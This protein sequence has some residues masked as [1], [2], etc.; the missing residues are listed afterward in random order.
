[1]T[2]YGSL[3][4]T[5]ATTSIEDEISET[6]KSWRERLGEKLENE[7]FHLAVL[8]LVL[9]DAACVIIQIVYTFF[10]EC[11]VPVVVAAALYNNDNSGVH[12]K[13]SYLLIAFEMAEVISIS[14]CLLFLVECLLCLIAFGPR[15]YLPGW[16][17]WKLH[18]FDAAVVTTTLVLEVGL[19]GKEREVAGLLIILRLWR[20]VKIIEAAIVSVSFAREEELEELKTKY[21]ELEAKYKQEQ[22][23]NQQLLAQQP[24]QQ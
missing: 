10:H 12:S 2:S 1:M 21:A 3:N 19:K 11:Q 15:Y 23:K 6:T 4:N 14:I 24:Q 22:E 8:G 9:V 18:V 7:K 16:E 17:H 5:T 20:V 13:A